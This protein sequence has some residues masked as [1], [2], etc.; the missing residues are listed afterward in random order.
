MIKEMLKK[1][2]PEKIWGYLTYIYLVLIRSE[3][4]YDYR[5]KMLLFYDDYTRL[6]D[7]HEEILYMKRKNQ[8]TMFPYS[9]TEKYKNRDVE[10]LFDEKLQLPY[11]LF[12]G[13]QKRL[14]YPDDMNDDEIKKVY[15]SILT[16]QDEES[17]H[18]YFSDKYEFEDNS[19]FIDV[20]SAEGNMALEVA[21]RAKAIVLF[22]GNA[23]WIPALRAT[24]APY[25][26]KVYII[27]K[28]VS[29]IIGQKETTI[30]E[31]LKN[32]AIQGNVYIKIDAEGSERKIIRGAEH[33]L[34]ER[35]VKCACCTY[36]KQNDAIELRDIF[37][38]KGF[39]HEF[40]KGY[41]LFKSTKLSYPYFRKGLVRVKNY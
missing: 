1:I 34:N 8:L 36:H 6:Q 23:R 19:I 35:K 25:G 2:F 39:I 22:E 4:R 24:F 13:G 32:Y 17:P 29:D 18:C 10:V 11:V 26:D 31:T 15:L 33:T 3:E 27:N 7:Y 14:Y 5:L 41:V 37:K 21:D 40:S 38:K 20:G 30:D 16:E 28:V 9:F 12:G